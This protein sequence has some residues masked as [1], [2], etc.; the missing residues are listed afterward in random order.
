MTSAVMKG[1]TEEGHFIRPG[2]TRRLRRSSQRTQPE[3]RE[4]ER[5][6][7]LRVQWSWRIEVTGE[8]AVGKRLQRE[9][10]MVSQL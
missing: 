7:C 8:G 3:Q 2:V 6:G 5:T 1:S 10:G 9:A 4:S